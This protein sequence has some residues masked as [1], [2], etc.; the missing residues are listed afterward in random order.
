MSV[1]KTSLVFALTACLVLKP[2]LSDEAA[3]APSPSLK[4]DAERAL[5]SLYASSPSAA[6]MGT[7]AKAILVFPEVFKIGFMFAGSH[8]EGVLLKDGS[9]VNHYQTTGGSFGFQ[10]GA[11]TYGYAV[12]LM[13]DDAVDYLDR[14]KGWELGAGPSITLIDQGL[15]KRVSSTTINTDAYA[16]VFGQRGLMAGVGVEGSKISLLDH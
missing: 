14:S 16:V 11:H 15:A 8:G 10:A 9:V 2:V 6:E 1:A 7:K 4:A 5:Q 13:T 3:A 12:F